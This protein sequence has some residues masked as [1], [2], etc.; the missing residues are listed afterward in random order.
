MVRQVDSYRCVKELNQIPQTLKLN[1]LKSVKI[2]F[3]VSDWASDFNI[4]P[5]S[6]KIW[7]F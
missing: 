1:F 5:E 3:F 6:I 7:R 2:R 4:L